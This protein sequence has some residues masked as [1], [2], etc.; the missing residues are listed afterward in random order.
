MP[1][2]HL[3][4]HVTVRDGPGA[5]VCTIVLKDAFVNYSLADLLKRGLKDLCSEKLQA[6]VREFVVDLSSV[7]VMDSCGLSVLISVKKLVDAESG[8]VCLAS[9]SPMIQRLFTITKL[10]RAFDIVPA[11]PDEVSAST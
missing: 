10:D 11:A 6:G 2:S 4:H 3:A 9:L 7:T 1:E 8:R 5:G